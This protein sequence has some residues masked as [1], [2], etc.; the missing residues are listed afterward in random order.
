MTVVVGGAEACQEAGV[1]ES[2]CIVDFLVR[3]VERH[4]SAPSAL[5]LGAFGQAHKSQ[6]ASPLSPGSCWSGRMHMKWVGVGG[7]GAVIS[8]QSYC[9]LQYLV[10]SP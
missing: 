6:G 2:I 8:A 1:L 3:V 5:A 7:W 9:H 10:F 4:P